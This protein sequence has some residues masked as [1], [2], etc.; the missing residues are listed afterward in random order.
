V[1]DLLG[2]IDIDPAHPSMPALLG[3]IPPDLDHVTVSLKSI[4]RLV[5]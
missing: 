5:E 2:R 1:V 4:E 3:G